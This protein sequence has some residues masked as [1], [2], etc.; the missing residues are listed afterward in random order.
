[1]S[2][3]RTMSIEKVFQEERDCREELCG[4]CF[5]SYEDKDLRWRMPRSFERICLECYADT[6][7]DREGA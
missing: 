1:M 5:N 2:E 3:K 7:R 4:S 6:E